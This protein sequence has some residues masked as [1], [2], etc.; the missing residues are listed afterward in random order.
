MNMPSLQDGID[1]AG[2]AIDFM[3]TSDDKTQ[4]VLV[5]P[6]EFG[7]WQ[8]EQSAPR[9]GVAFLDLSHHMG[10]VFVERP[11]ATRL[12]T[13]ISADDYDDFELGGAKLIDLTDYRRFVPMY[14][15]K[16]M[17]KL[18]GSFYSYD[19]Q[20]YYRSPFDLGYGRSIKFDHDFIG[21]PALE[22]AKGNSKRKRVTLVWDRADVDTALAQ[23]STTSSGSARTVLKATATLSAVR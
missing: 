4:P 1:G 3:W 14:S 10:Q 16:G 20:D 7:G 12:L 21:R 11:D 6:P 22:A 17:M 8:S 15:H 23:T 5:V 18:Y 13:A 2:S 9:H 19:F